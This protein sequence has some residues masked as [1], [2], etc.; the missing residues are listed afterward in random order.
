MLRLSHRIVVMANGRVQGTLD[1]AE[2]TQN[3]IMELATRF[4][5]GE[6]TAA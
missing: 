5:A 1:S 4:D 3:S 2:A 6:G